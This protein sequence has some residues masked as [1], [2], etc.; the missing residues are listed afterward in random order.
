MWDMWIVSFLSPY[1]D[2]TVQYCFYILQIFQTWDNDKK[3]DCPI[4]V[5][6]SSFSAIL[7][8]LFASLFNEH[9]CIH[10][11]NTFFTTWV[12]QTLFLWS[13]IR[14]PTNFYAI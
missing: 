4:N 11:R 8:H 9:F 13:S 14:N 3:T 6:M 10:N 1:N 5:R 2:V 12:Q 7:F